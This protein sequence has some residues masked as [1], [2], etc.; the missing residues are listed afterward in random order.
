LKSVGSGVSF[1]S[2]STV[3]GMGVIFDTPDLTGEIFTK[4]TDFALDRPLENMPVYYDHTLS[5]L[6][7]QI[8]H[9]T[10]YSITDEG[11]EFELELYKSHQYWEVVRDLVDAGVIGMST[12]S[13]PHLVSYS[14][15]NITRWVLA[16]VSLTTTPAEYRTIQK[17][18]I[19]D[20]LG[21]I[22]KSISTIVEMLQEKTQVG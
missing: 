18:V 7:S 5:G 16:E 9:V 3:R 13:A 20:R 6:K 21:R 17:D 10:A 19:D 4:N 1:V 15:K 14:G 2:E 22:V 8:G 11:I 12:G